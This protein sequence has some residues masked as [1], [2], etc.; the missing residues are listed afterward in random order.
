[1]KT[2][3]KPNVGEPNAVEI[4]DEI[5]HQAALH[6]ALHGKSTAE[7]R[8]WSRELGDVLE[9]RLAELRRNLTPPDAPVEK[10]PPIPASL[11]KLGR[12]ALL[13]RIAA[14][15]QA[16]GGTVQYA[17]RNLKGL[18]VNDLRRLLATIDPNCNQ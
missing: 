2:K 17:H 15:T 10:A 11:L 8:K 6:E 1:M 9:V 7:D 14:V 4:L 18:S 5:S 3:N 16:M 13:A 12:D